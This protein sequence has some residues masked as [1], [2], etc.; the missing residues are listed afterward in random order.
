MQLSLFAI[1]CKTNVAHSCVLLEYYLIFVSNPLSCFPFLCFPIIIYNRCHWSCLGILKDLRWDLFL[2]NTIM[3]INS[4][5]G[6]LRPPDP[7]W[8][9]GPARPILALCAAD[10]VRAWTERPLSCQ[11]W[12]SIGWIICLLE[13]KL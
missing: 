7:L 12:R 9:P 6:D 3:L 11:V 8:S 2:P 10:A 4:C 1:S 13:G 5:F